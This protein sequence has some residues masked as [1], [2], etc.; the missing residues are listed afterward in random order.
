MAFER[1]GVCSSESSVL[2]AA[3]DV[4]VTHMNEAASRVSPVGKHRQ[5]MWK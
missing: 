1:Y 2:V 4:P 3:P 5:F